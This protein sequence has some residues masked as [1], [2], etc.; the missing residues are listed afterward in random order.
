MQVDIVKTGDKWAVY[1]RS[2]FE[3]DGY[4]GDPIFTGDEEVDCWDWCDRNNH[5]LRR[6]RHVMLVVPKFVKDVERRADKWHADML[7]FARGSGRRFVSNITYHASAAWKE[8]PTHYCY[9]G[10]IGGSAS[11]VVEDKSLEHNGAAKQARNILHM[12]CGAAI[13][14]W[15]LGFTLTFDKDGKHTVYGKYPRWVTLDDED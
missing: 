2:A 11:F 5:N 8:E 7:D 10:D 4:R 1:P 3:Y 6:R 12:L 14:L 15:E 13:T 9:V